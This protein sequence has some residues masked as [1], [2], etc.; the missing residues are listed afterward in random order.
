MQ[1]L[2]YLF[3]FTVSITGVLIETFPLIPSAVAGREDLPFENLRGVKNLNLEVDK[4]DCQLGMNK[5]EIVSFVYSYLNNN[6]I[7]ASTNTIQT[8]SH[9]LNVSVNC[10]YNEFLSIFSI[11]L[12]V[13]QFINLDGVNTKVITYDNGRYGVIGAD[14]FVQVEKQQLLELLQEFVYDWKTVR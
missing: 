10:E 6:N 4:K 8:S 11:D 2:K 3:F 1:K 9:V 14:P 7:P 12:Q 5:T 13:N